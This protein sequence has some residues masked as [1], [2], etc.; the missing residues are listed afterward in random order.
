MH[1]DPLQAA[2]GGLSPETVDA[3][4]RGAMK[5]SP[6]GAVAIWYYLLDMPVEKWVSM[7][8]LVFTVLQIVVLIRREF[9]KRKGVD[10]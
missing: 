9:V 8:V 2:S 1:N 5:A 3:A 4:T 7:A 10:K 6:G